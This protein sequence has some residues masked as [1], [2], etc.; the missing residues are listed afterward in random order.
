MKTINF[1]SRAFIALSALSF[2]YVSLIG[3][4]NPQAVMD[5]VQVKLTNTDAYSSIRGVYGGVG[6]TIVATLIYMFIK[7]PLNGLK[8]LT[9]IW[10]MY[11]LSRIMTISMEGKLGAFGSKWLGIELFFCFTALTLLL[12]NMRKRTV[13]NQ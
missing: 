6:I 12:L 2:L 13:T 8:F 3:L 4:A 1:F 9:M 5:L 11:A 7:S 10:G